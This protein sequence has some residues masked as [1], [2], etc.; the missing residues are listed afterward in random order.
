[1]NCDDVKKKLLDYYYGEISPSLLDSLEEH[2]LLCHDCRSGWK[3]I[4]TLLDTIEREEAILLPERFW[5]D[6]TDKV[7]GKIEKKSRFW[8]L[9]SYPRLVPTVAVS[10]LFL[11]IIFGG[12]R[13]KE[14][15]EEKKLVSQYALLANLDLLKNLDLMQDFELIQ[16][17]DEVDN[18]RT[19]DK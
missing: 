4:K 9:F 11:T 8:G 6:Y 18:T 7:Y 19:E 16:H 3:G 17:L 5:R 13:L 10:V 15:R 1:M 2:L 12:L 14:V